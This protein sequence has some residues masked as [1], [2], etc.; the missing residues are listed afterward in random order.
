MRGIGTR[1]QVG[2]SQRIRVEWLE[3]TTGLL[4]A[5]CTRAQIEAA[6]ISTGGRRAAFRAIADS[7]SLFPFAIDLI[8][9]EELDCNSRL[10]CFRHGLGEQVVAVRG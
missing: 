8:R 4:L 6:L 5:G 10:E 2:F 1:E 9:G 3:Q 7:P